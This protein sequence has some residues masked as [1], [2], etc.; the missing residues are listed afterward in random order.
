MKSKLTYVYRKILQLLLIITHFN[1]RY[2]PCFSE[3]ANNPL[4][5]RRAAKAAGKGILYFFS[6]NH[7]KSVKMCNV[8]KFQHII[9][10]R[11]GLGTQKYVRSET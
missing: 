3:P 6:S 11:K 2:I 5:A 9:S 8:K 7:K 1:I 10:G 4:F